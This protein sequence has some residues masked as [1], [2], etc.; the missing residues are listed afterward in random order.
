MFLFPLEDLYREYT[1]LQ[2][3]FLRYLYLYFGQ[4]MY[5]TILIIANLSHAKKIAVFPKK[6]YDECN[7]QGLIFAIISIAKNDIN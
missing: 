2:D 5:F 7:N 6:K 1:I 4:K 3:K